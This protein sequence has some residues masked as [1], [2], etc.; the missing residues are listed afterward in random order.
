MNCN[1]SKNVDVNY[2]NDYSMV[3]VQTFMPKN[4]FQVQVVNLLMISIHGLVFPTEKKNLMKN[5]ILEVLG[6]LDKKYPRYKYKLGT[7]FSDR[8]RDLYGS[9]D[10]AE[11]LEIFDWVPGTDC[12]YKVGAV[13]FMPVQGVFV[14]SESEDHF[15]AAPFYGD[16]L[17]WAAKYNDLLAEKGGAK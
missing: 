17:G 13:F 10:N 9:A 3:F 6:K 1:E 12:L 14:Q 11:R 7:V 4:K 5:D 16:R 2:I 15:F 8:V